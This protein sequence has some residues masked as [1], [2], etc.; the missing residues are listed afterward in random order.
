[1]TRAEKCLLWLLRIDAV[2]LLSALIPVVIPSVWMQEIH[3][4]MG[5]G[6]LPTGPIVEYLTRSISL[7][8]ALHGVTVLWVSTDLR[9]YLPI[10]TCFGVLGICFGGGML[11]IDAWAGMPLGWTIGEGPFLMLLGGVILK[12]AGRVAAE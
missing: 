6:E 1:M 7:L 12:L 2:V 3:R 10:V 5:M 8:Y 4:R 9:R 11:A